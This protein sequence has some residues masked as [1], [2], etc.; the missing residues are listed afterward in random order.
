MWG[1]LALVTPHT[2]T[3]D[4]DN[5]D[6]SFDV[7][8][9]PGQ[10]VAFVIFAFQ[11]PNQATIRAQVDSIVADV[12]SH[13]EDLTAE[14]AA[15]IVNWTVDG[16]V[17]GYGVTGT[18]DYTCEE[19]PG[20]VMLADDCN[21]A[22]PTCYPAAEEI[23]DALDND[24]DGSIDEGLTVTIWRDADGD[25]FGN[26]PSRRDDCEIPAGYVENGDDCNDASDVVNPDADEICD[27]L[28]NDCNGSVDEELLSTFF[29][30]GDGDG[31][32]DAESAFEACVAPE[33]A[34]DNGDDCDDE[35]EATN[36]AAEEIVDGSDNDCNGEIDDIV[37]P[38]GDGDGDL[39]PPPPEGCDCTVVTAG[40]N[41]S[42]LS[43]LVLG[44]ISL[45]L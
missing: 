10:T 40:G 36:P 14:E 15:R 32:G 11:G 7:T 31:F 18:E 38:D 45:G 35:D 20:W 43:R 9:E 12:A 6:T 23:C 44:V 37:A 2:Q 28:D 34:V 8:I 41:G 17:D 5:I 3:I 30:D 21:D 39:P 42:G 26:G 27:G 16:D 22:C 24:C 4:R 25:G 1:E 13:L 19:R 29:T 33:G